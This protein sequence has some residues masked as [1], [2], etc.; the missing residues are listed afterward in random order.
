MSVEV[1]EGMSLDT[2]GLLVMKPAMVKEAGGCLRVPI[3]TLTGSEVAPM[4]GGKDAYNLIKVPELGPE[5]YGTY[6][7]CYL[8]A[9]GLLCQS[10]AKPE[11]PAPGLSY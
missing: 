5:L 11:P 6:C 3:A 4:T 8:Y 7:C 9:V 10:R 2:R 1:G